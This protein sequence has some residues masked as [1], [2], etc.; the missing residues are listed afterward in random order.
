MNAVVELSEQL[1]NSPRHAGLPRPR[2]VLAFLSPEY[3]TLPD[4]TSLRLTSRSVPA[5]PAPVKD[6]NLVTV[7]RFCLRLRRSRSAWQRSGLASCG[8]YMV[9]RT[10]EDNSALM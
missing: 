5:T 4:K 8:R 1:D 9:F 7:A 10:R 3:L 2:T 6:A